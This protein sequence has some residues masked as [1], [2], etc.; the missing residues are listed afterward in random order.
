MWKK[1]TSEVIFHILKIFTFWLVYDWGM[2]KDFP[3]S[4]SRMALNSYG[5]YT[6]EKEI[7]HSPLWKGTNFA[8]YKSNKHK[9]PN[10]TT[11][12]NVHTKTPPTA[13]CSPG[14]LKIKLNLNKSLKSATFR[15]CHLKY[16]RFSCGICGFLV[17]CS[18]VL[19]WG[20]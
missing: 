5:S 7:L 18:S 20:R 1:V 19:T 13:L 14:G 9:K 15:F 2:L 12:P 10:Q 4:F 11:K 8:L 6:T 17:L 16:H 3:C